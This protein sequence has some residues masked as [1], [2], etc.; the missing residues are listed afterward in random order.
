MIRRENLAAHAHHQERHSHGDGCSLVMTVANAT[1]PF[2]APNPAFTG[3][4]RDCRTEITLRR[5]QHH[6]HGE[7]RRREPIPSPPLCLILTM[8][9][10]GYTV[11]I[12]PGTL[13]ITSAV[14]TV[15]AANSS[16]FYGDPNPA[17]TGA[18]TGIR[19]TETTSRPPMPVPPLRPA[20][21]ARMQS[22]P[23]FLITGPARLRT[24]RW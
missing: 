6:G 12:N 8:L 21:L 4:S 7:Q 10:G 23:R 3:I 16:R 13:T 19:I 2:G 15:T 1:R 14:L 24:T 9:F 5:L 17:F 20:W 22:C 11:T 18:I